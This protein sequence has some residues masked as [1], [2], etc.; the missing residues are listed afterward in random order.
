MRAIYHCKILY[1][2]L[3]Q[4]GFPEDGEAIADFVLNRSG[5]YVIDGKKALLEYIDSLPLEQAYAQADN[6][7]WDYYFGK[8]TS[9]L[10]KSYLN[11]KAKNANAS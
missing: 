8:G 5:K 2:I 3:R 4:R 7:E 6:E 11:D 10:I 9:R 1:P